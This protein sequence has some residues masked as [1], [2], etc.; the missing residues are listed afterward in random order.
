MKARARRTASLV[1]S[2]P[3]LVKRRLGLSEAPRQ[4]AR[5]HAHV[6]PRLREVRAPGDLLADRLHDERVGV[7]DDH[8]PEPVVKIDVFVP[9]DVPDPAALAA[10]GEY[11]LRRRVLVRGGHAARFHLARLAPLLVG[12]PPI[13]A[14]GNLLARDQ[15]LDALRAERYCRGV[16]CQITSLLCAAS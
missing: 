5:H 3:L 9:V 16:A 1:D 8:D 4:V 2:V 11:R 12:A 14:E 7:A 15:R 6:V 13:G 10:L